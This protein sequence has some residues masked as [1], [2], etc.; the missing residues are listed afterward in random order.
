ML[1]TTAGD[2]MVLPDWTEVTAAR[3]Y[4]FLRGATAV[5][6]ALQGPWYLVTKPSQWVVTPG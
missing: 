2:A 3:N 1:K 4:R 6:L 5:L